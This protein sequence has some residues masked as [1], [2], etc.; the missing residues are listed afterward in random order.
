MLRAKS[1]YS[2]WSGKPSRALSLVGRVAAHPT[3]SPIASNNV[4]TR[5][6]RPPT[7]PVIPVS[8]TLLTYRNARESAIPLIERARMNAG[9]SAGPTFRISGTVPAAG[10]HLAEGHPE[11]LARPVQ[12]QIRAQEATGRGRVGQPWI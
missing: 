3:R 9:K 5:S 8:A 11:R 4:R 6:P 10:H 7:R 2:N 12:R 1:R